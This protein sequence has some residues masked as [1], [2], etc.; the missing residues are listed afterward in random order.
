MLSFFGGT[1]F[2]PIVC[3]AVFVVVGIA[4]FYVWP[5]VQMGI[6]ALGDLVI[7]SGYAGTWIYGLLE[8]ALAA[9]SAGRRHGFRAPQ[10]SQDRIAAVK[11]DDAPP[12]S[13]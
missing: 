8:R 1:R 11:H 12:L 3:T 2:V 6:A 10:G 13:D 5:S 7:R 9:Q 4:M